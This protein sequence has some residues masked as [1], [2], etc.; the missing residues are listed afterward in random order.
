MTATS[1]IGEPVSGRDDRWDALRGLALLLMILTHFL[2]IDTRRYDGLAVD[3]LLTTDF[4]S[5]VTLSVN[6]VASYMAPFLFLF[7]TGIILELK[8]H[9]PGRIMP[10]AKII[11]RT[12]LLVGLAL[13]T[14]LLLAL[15][16][17]GRENLHWAQLRSHLLDPNILVVIAMTY[18]VCEFGLQKYLRYYTQ[19]LAV[20]IGTV[21]ILGLAYLML[22]RLFPA[23]PGDDVRLRWLAVL[24]DGIYCSL[25]GSV[26]YAWQ[27]DRKL[28]GAF[29]IAPLLFVLALLLLVGL[30]P[31]LEAV[32]QYQLAYYLIGTAIAITG[33]YLLDWL[34]TAGFLRVY[35]Q[36]VS[37][38]RVSLE[39]YLVHFAVGYLLEWFILNP[40]IPRAWWGINA[41]FVAII[42]LTYSTRRL[43][44]RTGHG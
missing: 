38:G 10:A 3:A 39:L 35:A 41:L 43:R 37:L 20:K 28:W 33:I 11:R 1:R 23:G 21:A 32:K 18:L 12:V 7:I 2:Y 5:L 14:N 8:Y 36:L 19:G 13:A 26:Y 9:V 30:R 17:L 25:L 22:N 15:H 34:K 31:P 4:F 44:G 40:F 6:T 42:S 16:H 27:R 24:A 29:W